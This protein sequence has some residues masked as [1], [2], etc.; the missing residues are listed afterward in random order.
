MRGNQTF[1]TPITK[2]DKQS[3][4]SSANCKTLILNTQQSTNTTTN[5][6][7]GE[8]SKSYNPLNAKPDDYPPGNSVSEEKPRE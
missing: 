6:L 1:V 7:N 8:K 5:S 4:N 3:P 2:P